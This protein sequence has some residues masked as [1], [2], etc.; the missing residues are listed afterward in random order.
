MFDSAI[1]IC[2]AL[3]RYELGYDMMGILL[4][5]SVSKG[6]IKKVAERFHEKMGSLTLKL[7]EVYIIFLK[8]WNLFL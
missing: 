8:T 6:C 2:A 1:I 7:L 5:S 3:L 4:H